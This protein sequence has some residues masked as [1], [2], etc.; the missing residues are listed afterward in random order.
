MEEVNYT[1]L[2]QALRFTVSYT[3]NRGIFEANKAPQAR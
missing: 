3:V 2:L 1:L